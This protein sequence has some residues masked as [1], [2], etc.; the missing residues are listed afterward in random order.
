MQS[1]PIAPY[2]SN[3]TGVDASTDIGDG[4]LF[5]FDTEAEPI[6]ESLVNISMEQAML[7]VMHEEQVADMRR[8]QQEYMAIREAEMAELRRLEAEDARLQSEKERR[9][10][11]EQISA[12][13]DHEMHERITAAKMIQGYVGNLLPD[14]IEAMDL[15]VNGKSLTELEDKLKPWLAQE[16]AE[17]VGQMIDSR[18][19]LEDIVRDIVDNRAEAYLNTIETEHSDADETAAET[20][21]DLSDKIIS[22]DVNDSPDM[23]GDEESMGVEQ[24]EKIEQL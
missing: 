16:V 11:L 4:D 10:R 17:E 1:P 24:I 18:E 6:I 9:L 12:D 5:D 19:L 21:T 20:M 7:E 2:I 15:Y 3:K 22:S 14:V 8:Q 13:L 23:N